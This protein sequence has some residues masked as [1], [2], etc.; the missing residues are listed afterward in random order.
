MTTKTK[1]T[2]AVK[3]S[4]RVEN[5]ITNAITQEFKKGL[6]L[7]NNMA[8]TGDE[9]GTLIKKWLKRGKSGIT[10]VIE[11]TEVQ[12]ANENEL[13]LNCINTACKRYFKSEKVD[14]SLKGIG[15]KTES[16]RKQKVEIT[17]KV[18]KPNS[19][20]G[21]A[22]KV[23]EGTAV[24]KFDWE[25]FKVEFKKANKETQAEYLRQLQE[26]IK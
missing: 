26:L 5:A 17:P 2:K 16:G 20:G 18:K 8:N 23:A 15:F 21:K 6:D 1:T 13:A 9:L 12:K 19:G 10:T 22:K 3:P 4:N 14:L 25:A 7:A 11:F 24:V